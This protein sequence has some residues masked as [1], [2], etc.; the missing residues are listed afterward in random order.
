VPNSDEIGTVVPMPEDTGPALTIN[1]KV[2][3][4]I[5]VPARMAFNLA[6]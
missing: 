3:K 6:I 5:R 1:K 2:S 4:P